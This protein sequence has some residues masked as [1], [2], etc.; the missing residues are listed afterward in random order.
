MC[1]YVLSCVSI[2]Y[3]I[4][5]KKD[6]GWEWLQLLESLRPNVSQACHTTADTERPAWLRHLPA[7]PQPAVNE[8]D[9]GM[10]G[11]CWRGLAPP[12]NTEGVGWV[13]P[14]SYLNTEMGRENF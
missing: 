6:M 4:I 7:C 13:G 9:P 8:P 14:P 11:K 1:Y 5:V 3:H 2:L 12:P 10:C